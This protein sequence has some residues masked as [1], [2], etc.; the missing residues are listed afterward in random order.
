MKSLKEYESIKEFIEMLEYQGMTNEKKQLEFI[1][2][3]V[4]TTEKQ[5]DA[6]LRELENVRTELGTIQQ[7]TIKATA[8]RAVDNVAS[9]VNLAKNNI[10]K[11]KKFIKNTVEKGIEEFKSK[12]KSALV[13]AM[14]VLNAKGILQ[15]CQYCFN[16]IQQSADQSINTLTRLGNEIHQMN[17]HFRNIGRIIIGKNPVTIK[18]RNHDNGIISLAQKGLFKIMETMDSLKFKAQEN[19]RKIDKQE[20]EL[21]SKNTAQKSSV[22]SA[23]DELK[24]NSPKKEKQ[25]EMAYKER[26]LIK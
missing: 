17:G 21:T 5:L 2:D 3:Y 7:K 11:T 25:K 24:K 15:N 19:I 14:T 12:G 9:K 1:V 4:D 8:I 18:K 20:Q 23:L 13:S 26:Q 6:V 10:V 16:R 22:K